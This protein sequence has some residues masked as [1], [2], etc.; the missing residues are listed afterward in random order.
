MTVQVL[1]EKATQ[2][3]NFTKKDG[4]TGDVEI[5]KND[6]GTYT[7]KG[8]KTGEVSFTVAST[9]NAEIKEDITFTVVERP[10]AAAFKANVLAKTFYGESD[11]FKGVVNFNEDGTGKFKVAT[12]SYYGTY[13]DS[14]QSFNWTF[15]EKTLTF[16]ITGA[17]GSYYSGKGFVSFVGVTIDEAKGSFIDYDYDQNATPFTLTLRAQDRKDLTEFN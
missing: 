1:P 6:D 4:A 15:D 16:T 11:K 5:N 12:V 17:T 13:Y 2:D 14:E 10:S 9:E 7:V 3:V 8:T